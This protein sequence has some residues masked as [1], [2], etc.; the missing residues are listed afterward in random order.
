MIPPAASASTA[1]AISV[2]RMTRWRFRKYRKCHDQ[3]FSRRNNEI[4]QATRPL[5]FENAFSWN[6]VWNSILKCVL[7]S[8]LKSEIGAKA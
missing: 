1:E 6:S 8:P 2:A 4:H 5:D 3:I 7:K